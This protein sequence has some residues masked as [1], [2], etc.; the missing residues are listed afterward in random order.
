VPYQWHIVHRLCADYG[1]TLERAWNAP[2]AMAR[3]LYDAGA[4]AEGD[5]TIMSQR[6]QEMEDTWTATAGEQ[7][8]AP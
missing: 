2:Y 6:A 4:E 7:A 1:Y 8:V 3:C 5:D